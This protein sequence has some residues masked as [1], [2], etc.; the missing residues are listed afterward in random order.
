MSK[1]ERKA[2]LRA[3]LVTEGFERDFGW[4]IL[5]VEFVEG[6]ELGVSFGHF[7]TF[8]PRPYYFVESHRIGISMD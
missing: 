2:A 8:L 3:E 5:G 4:T 6:G 1:E 7:L